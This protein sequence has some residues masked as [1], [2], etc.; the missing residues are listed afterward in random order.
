MKERNVKQVLFGV[1]NS[2]KQE[3]E[4]R[5]SRRYTWSMY[6]IYLYES[7]ALTPVE[8]ISRSGKGMM[9]NDGGSESNQGTW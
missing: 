3:G 1:S 6:F 7:R 2:G 4:W 9:E 5:G 8:I